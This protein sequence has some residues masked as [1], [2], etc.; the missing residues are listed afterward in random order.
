MAVWTS[1]EDLSERGEHDRQRQLMLQSL[2]VSILKTSFG[3]MINFYYSESKDSNMLIHNPT[4]PM[5]CVRHSHRSCTFRMKSLPLIFKPTCSGHFICQSI[6]VSSS[7]FPS[8]K[9]CGKAERQGMREDLSHSAIYL[10]GDTHP[11]ATAPSQILGYSR[12]HHSRKKC[13]AILA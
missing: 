10:T 1:L 3:I 5:C 9:F 7:G 6:P 4:I 12:P 2:A 11:T 8:C 13:M